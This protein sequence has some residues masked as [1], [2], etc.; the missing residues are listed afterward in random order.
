MAVPVLIQWVAN[1]T[2]VLFFPLAFSRLGKS[3]TFVFLAAMCA[4]KSLFIWRFV[5]QSKNLFLEK[6]EDY[7]KS[8]LRAAR[9]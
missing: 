9:T 7:W 2:V 4:A 5:P 6:I 1:A 3:V 8:P